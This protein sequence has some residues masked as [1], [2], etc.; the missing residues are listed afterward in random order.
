[1]LVYSTALPFL[2][3]GRI[4]ALSVSDS[5]RVPQLPDVRRIGEEDGMN[6][7]SLPLWQALFAK[8][9]TPGS[10]VLSVE[11]A[12]LDALAQPEVKSKLMEAGV[13]AAPM[14]G[15]D[16]PGFIKPQAALYREI[17]QSARITMD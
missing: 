9:G 16:L 1:M 17:V 12:M 2:K 11:K 8:A 7:V 13:T 10:V 5:A 3:E 14:S 15:R 6:G 4:K